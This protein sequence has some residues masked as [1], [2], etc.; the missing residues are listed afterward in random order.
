MAVHVAVS[1]WHWIVSKFH[2]CLYYHGST[3]KSG[4]SDSWP[5]AIAIVP[6]RLITNGQ[7]VTWGIGDLFRTVSSN[8]VPAKAMFSLSSMAYWLESSTRYIGLA[9]LNDSLVVFLFSVVVFWACFVLCWAMW[10]FFVSIGSILLIDWYLVF[11]DG[12]SFYICIDSHVSNVFSPSQIYYYRLL[13]VKYFVSYDSHCHMMRFSGLTL[14]KS[15][16]QKWWCCWVGF[17]SLNSDL[18]SDCHLGSECCCVCILVP[19]AM[20]ALRGCCCLSTDVLACR[21]NTKAWFQDLSP[22]PWDTNTYATNAF[23]SQNNFKHFKYIIY[24]YII[25]R[26]FQITHLWI[27]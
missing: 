17:P 26:C 10:M 5:I 18:V 1:P 2:Y 22:N 11:I 8:Q 19:A 24:M 27:P 21:K 6:T 16:R 7:W 9:N 23:F 25:H 14:S 4:N 20:D 13:L 12:F 3:V 15:E